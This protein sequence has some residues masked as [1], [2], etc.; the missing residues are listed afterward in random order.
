MSNRQ[1]RPTNCAVDASRHGPVYSSGGFRHEAARSTHPVV[2]DERVRVRRVGP[3]GRSEERHGR[4]VAALRIAD[5]RRHPEGRRQCGGRGSGRRLCA[6]RDQL[7][8]RQHRRRRL[9]DDPPGRRSRPLHQFPRDRAGRGVREHVSRCGGQRDSGPEPVRLPCGRRAGHGGRPRSRAAQ[10]READ[11]PAG[12]GAGDPA[13]ARRLRADARR[14]RHPRHDGRALQEGSGSR[15]HL[16]APGRHGAAAGRSPGAEGS[17][18]HA[19]AHRGAGARRVL[20]RRDPEDRGSG[21][22]ARR[23]RDHGGRFRV[24]SRAGHGAADMHVSRLRVRVGAAAELG[25]RDDV[26]D[27]EHPRRI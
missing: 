19:R 20:S 18:A 9:H 8:L 4:V 2:G 24:L 13:R 6:G 25:R 11:A 21:G 12:D 7:V 22:Q 3:G 23:R 17:G 27:A 16:P 5:R 10:I 26:R 1:R 14:Y 15:A